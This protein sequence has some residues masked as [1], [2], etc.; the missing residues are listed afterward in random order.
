MEEELFV[1]AS[2]VRATVG[3]VLEVLDGI[4][5]ECLPAPARVGTARKG[6]NPRARTRRDTPK[7]TQTPC[8]ESSDWGA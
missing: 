8:E 4:T 3:H 6:V 2:D 5:Q 7:N 1:A